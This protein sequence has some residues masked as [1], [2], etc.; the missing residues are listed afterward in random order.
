[1]WTLS[2][3]LLITGVAGGDP[4]ARNEARLYASA[5]RRGLG[6]APSKGGNLSIVPSTHELR[7]RERFPPRQ[8]VMSL[9]PSHVLTVQE[10]LGRSGLINRCSRNLPRT[11][12]RHFVLAVWVLLE[13]YSGRSSGVWRLWL[14]SLPAPDATIFWSDEELAVLE[15]ENAIRQTRIRRQKLQ[16]EYETMLRP[17]IDECGM[18]D[19][20]EL[21]ELVAPAVASGGRSGDGRSGG[22]HLDGG[23]AEAGLGQADYFWAA[24]VVAAHA[25][26]FASDFPVLV[27][28]TLRYHPSATADVAEWGSETDPGAALYA[29][30]AGIRAG[31]PIT[32][33]SE[34]ADNA[35]LLVHAGYVW[36][37]LD[38]ARPRLHLTAGQRGESEVGGTAAGSTAGG[39]QAS[40]VGVGGAEVGGAEGDGG[41][42][43]RGELEGGETRSDDPRQTEVRRRELLAAAN[44]TRAMDFELSATSLN[45]EMLTWL[46][47]VL[48]SPLEVR[49]A[50]SHEDF[51]TEA[52][53]ERVA[54][55]AERESGALN[56]L[57]ASVE[58]QLATYEFSIEED[59]AILQ[60]EQQRAAAAA[61][62][63]APS[64]RVVAVRHR[65][66]CKRV[67]ERTRQLASEHW[68]EWR[69]REHERGRGRGRGRVSTAAPAGG[70]DGSP[71]GVRAVSVNAASGT[72]AAAESGS[73]S[74]DP[75]R[76][77]TSLGATAGSESV[78][79]LT[80]GLHPS[81]DT[82]SARPDGHERK[83][84]KKRK[85]KQKKTQDAKA[86]T[87][88]DD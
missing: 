47:L 19:E 44:W 60:A 46:R 65:W 73:Q 66:L 20:L 15:D 83:K 17:L 40:R 37:D 28:L 82:P 49:L 32:V 45:P 54:W 62:G 1:M 16:Q 35:Y 67:L 86:G 24:S 68:T 42:E 88:K 33:W 13:R 61:A 56:V 80:G 25:W 63:A 6:I 31:E 70:G 48:A 22:D 51:G 71:S 4:P 38:A 58:R 39:T 81:S 10:A 77:L 87:Q 27:P 14:S 76:D 3:A 85:R 23:P 75:E 26:H 21:D 59:E 11:L 36:E 18:E 50:R 9:A 84:K 8:L 57:R 41:S 12:P 53:A 7:A 74:F 43:R 69:R 55:S 72:V 34:D 29:S 2:V 78:S 30:E 5:L 64:R 79:A 52:A